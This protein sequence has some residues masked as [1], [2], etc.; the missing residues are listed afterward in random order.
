MSLRLRDVVVTAGEARLLQGVTLDVAA[1]RILAVVGPNGA[2]KTTLL[3]AIS[4]VAPGARGTVEIAGEVD[5][6]RGGEPRRGVGRVFQ[7][8][9]LPET[10]TVAEVAAIATGDRRSA[11][12]LAQR[13]GLAPHATAFVAELS[14]GM[15]RILDL[16]VATVGSP[17]VL[18]LDEPASG[19]A[20]SEIEYLAEVLLRWRE[21]TGAAIVIV[22][23]DAWLVRA[24]ADEVV[25][26][27]QGRVAAQG[28]VGEVLTATHVRSRP[29]VRQRDDR[30]DASLGRVRAEAAPAPPLIR[31]TLST[32]TLLRLGLREFSAGL[33]SVLILGVLNRVLKV[34]L[35]VSLGVVAAV[36]ASYNLAAPVALPIGHWSDTRPLFGRRRTPYIVGGAIVTGLAVAAAPHVAGRLAG[37]VTAQAVVLSVALFVAMGLGMY[38][39]G[40]VFFA[41]LSDVSPPQERGN[42]AKVIYLELLA[43]ILFG[44][45]LTGAIVD[46]EAGNLGTLFALA[47]FM[48]VVLTTLAVWGQERRAIEQPARAPARVRL[49]A[50]LREVSRIRQA[51]L[52]FGFMVASTLFL[53]IQQAVLQPFGGDVFGMTV[54][55]TSGFNAML[56]LGTI[57]G[58]VTAG[59]PFAEQVGHRRVAW[60]GLWLSVSAFGGLAFAAAAAS[61]PATWLSLLFVGFGTGVFN[62]ATLA[63][64]MTMATR[65]RAALFMGAWTFAHALADGA[66]TAGGGIVYTVARAVTG[67]TTRG[68]AA[69]FA[70]EAIGLALC[71]PLLR[72]VDPSRFAAEAGEEERVE[73]AAPDSATALLAPLAGQD[74]AD[75]GTIRRGE[76]RATAR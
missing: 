60:A 55:Q 37:G 27:E 69:V 9:P 73:A 63:L 32:W 1:G 42:V 22:E 51:R 66:A 40:T 5:G 16:A 39:S 36:L 52:F 56:T 61:V 3:D 17:A 64:M 30:F 41:L 76:G 29:R 47:G 44:V 33:A 19:L 15:R 35:G 10:L 70:L 25:V 13:F 2:G 7:G 75:T 49:T 11:A 4:G 72:R 48:I 67:S 6:G 54:E 59:R 68:Y 50:A 46:E 24:V 12:A 38:G 62:V 57:V 65:A 20:Q 34:E 28:S 45:G 43:G 8:S 26:L 18:L 21:Q 74:G 23:H 53:F 58:M 71:L 14:T 31:R